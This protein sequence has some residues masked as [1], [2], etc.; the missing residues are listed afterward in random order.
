VLAAATSILLSA[1]AV[2]IW[3]LSVRP[4][5]NDLIAAFVPDWRWAL[6]ISGGLLFSLL[7]AAVEEMA[8]RGVAMG[9][10]VDDHT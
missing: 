1:A 6:L 5:I 3:S 4:D 7:N 9:A 10:L 2:I 8:Y